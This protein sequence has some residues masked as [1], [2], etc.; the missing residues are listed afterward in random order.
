M[1]YTKEAISFEIQADRLL[2]RGLS[3]DRAELIMRVEA[4]SYY[5]LA[6]YLHPFRLPASD[7]FKEGTNL[8]TVWKRYCFDRRLRVLM[9]DAIERIEVSIRTKLVY[10]FAHAHGPFGHLE[11]KH[12][13]KLKIAEYLDWR[14][15]LL[16]ETERSKEPFKKHFF[17][18]YGDSHQELPLWMLA[19]LMSMG[20]LL[21]FFKGTSPELKR[22][23]AGEYGLADELLHSWLRSLNAVRNLCAHHARLWNRE[24]GYPPLLPQPNK[25]PAWHAGEKVP[26]HRCGII[27]M[28]CRHL[29]ALISP[30]SQW[31]VRVEALFTEYPEVPRNEMGLPEDWT[32][33]PLWK[34][35]IKL[36]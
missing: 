6:G 34:R 10:N 7:Q 1:E 5:R 4:V 21:T 17:A 20:S 24:L 35:E 22:K 28:I 19:E 13:P 33:H 36:I 2:S 27:L 18:Q 3:A 15:S 11:S 31:A 32:K 26:N 29:L 8:P 23:V 25:F 14:G 16:E 30:T 12:L 9:L